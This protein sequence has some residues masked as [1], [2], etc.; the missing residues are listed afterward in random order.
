MFKNKLGIAALVIGVGVLV[1]FVMQKLKKDKDAKKQSVPPPAP[2]T[3]TIAEKIAAAYNNSLAHLKQDEIKR[4]SG[5]IDAINT[6]VLNQK[7][8]ST[9]QATAQMIKNAQFLTDLANVDLKAVVAYWEKA[10][11]IKLNKSIF[12]TSAIY[13]GTQTIPAFVRRIK[14]VF[15]L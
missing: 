1:V 6:D 7:S 12:Y 8:K 14:D 3:G 2:Q 5:W 10:R 11:G 15:N 4:Y 9:I 13:D